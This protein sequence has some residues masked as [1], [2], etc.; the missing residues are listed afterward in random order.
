[1]GEARGGNPREQNLPVRV[2]Q[3]EDGIE[4]LEPLRWSSSADI[5]GLAEADGF[6][7]LPA[8]QGIETGAMTLWRPL[9]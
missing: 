5:V 9:R 6:A 7:R 1:M 8:E 2:H 3:G 4:L